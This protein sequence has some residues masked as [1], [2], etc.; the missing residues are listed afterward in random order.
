MYMIDFFQNCK[1]KSEAVFFQECDDILL[2]IIV[3]THAALDF[4]SEF[5]FYFKMYVI[6]GWQGKSDGAIDGFQ[7]ILYL[8]LIIVLFSF[9]RTPRR[10][11]TV[12]NMF[13]HLPSDLVGIT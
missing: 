10:N 12:K 13:A 11:S 8:A 1:Y 7:N 4:G 9:D 2:Y 5:I 3:F 6:M